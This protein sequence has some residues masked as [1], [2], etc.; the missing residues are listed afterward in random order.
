MG[1][2]VVKGT[3]GIWTSGGDAPG[4]NP[5]IRAVVRAALSKGYNVKG[6]RHGYN[7]LLT[8]DIFDMDLRSVSEIIHRG[9]TM[10]YTARS[11]EFMTEEGQ[12]K[13]AETCR[14]YGIDTLVVIGGDG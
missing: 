3:I 8:D 13:A 6:I 11:M 1:E 7:G 12:Q 10:L 5:A 2:N 14:R 9:G 4:M